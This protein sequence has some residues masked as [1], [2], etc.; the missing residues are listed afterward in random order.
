MNYIQITDC[1][2]IH[3]GHSQFV[4]TTLSVN[5]LA[6]QIYKL[7]EFLTYSGY[8]HNRT[9]V[10]MDTVLKFLTTF[11]RC[12]I[13][14]NDLA[15]EIAGEEGQMIDIDDLV[16]EFWSVDIAKAALELYEE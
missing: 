2:I 5:E 4:A 7:Q 10:D 13:I 16:S 3:G 6:T 1:N 12:K 14:D 15:M 11:C 8:I 9:I